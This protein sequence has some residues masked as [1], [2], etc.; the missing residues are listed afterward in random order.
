[1]YTTQT[2]KWFHHI[3]YTFNAMLN[4]NNKTM[5]VFW[6]KCLNSIHTFCT[7]RSKPQ[8]KTFLI[9]SV[10]HMCGSISV[11]L[12]LLY[13]NSRALK[14]TTEKFAKMNKSK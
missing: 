1:M 3:Y 9:E 7:L 6:L 11:S 8:N 14:R 12:H 5:L 2:Y 10:K 4:C 13:L